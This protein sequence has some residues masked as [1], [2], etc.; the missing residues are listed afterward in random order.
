MAAKG[1]VAS[2][3]AKELARKNARLFITGNTANRGAGI[4]SNGSIVFGRMPQGEEYRKLLKVKKEWVGIPES[5]LPA[6]VLIKV[7]LDSGDGKHALDTL[8][9]T[10]EN[11]WSAELDNLPTQI[12]G[13]PIEQIL[14]LEE[15]VPAGM[16][17]KWVPIV[18]EISRSEADDPAP[19]VRYEEG[20]TP[21]KITVHKQAYLAV[22]DNLRS[23]EV[24][25]EKKWEAPAAGEVTVELLADGEVRESAV[26]KEESGWKHTFTG[27]PAVTKDNREIV[28]TVRESGSDQG[29]V[30]IGGTTY[31]SEITGDAEKGFT[32][33]NSEAVSVTASKSWLGTPLASVTIELLADGTKV[34]EAI[35]S[36]ENDWSHTFEGLQKLDPETKKEIVYTVR[37][38]GAASGILSV[39]GA[40]YRVEV[41]GTAAEGYTVKNVELTEIQVG[42]SWNGE[43]QSGAS[44]QLLADGQPFAKAELN[45]ENGWKHTFDSLDVYREDGSKIEYSVREIGGENGVI[46]YDKTRYRV[47]I[48]GDAASG[49][50]VKNSELIDI[51]VEKA[52]N[53][54]ERDAVAIEL[55]ANGEVAGSAELTAENGWKHVFEGL[56]KNDASGKAIDYA[57]REVGAENGSIAFDGVRYASEITGDANKGFK[58]KNTELTSLSVEKKWIGEQAKSVTVML[59]ANGQPLEE[60]VLDESNAWSHAFPD[61]PVNDGNQTPIEYSVR[62]KGEIAGRVVLD[63]RDYVV[64]LKGSAK[65]G[66][67]LINE[68]VKTPVVEKTKISVEKKWAGHEG[69]EA[70]IELLANG[71]E[72]GAVKLLK[73]NGWKYAFEDLPVLGADDMP[74]V[75]TVRERGAKDQKLVL[76]GVTYRVEISGD[77]KNGFTVTNTGKPEVPEKPKTP[78][79]PTTGDPTAVLFGALAGAGALMAVIERK[80]R[81]MR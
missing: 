10:K 76:D 75:Y 37:E 19:Y 45:A 50:A 42:K 71:E 12:D 3:E 52:W 44:I 53:G 59:L 73:A 28:Y 27:L 35:L 24:S 62:E 72:I 39:E 25:V 54:D 31:H 18:G 68:E 14:S 22:V 8:K 79:S 69:K 43:A 70:T 78:P 6:E 20:E 81:G 15:I 23:T 47:E 67:T 60:A 21:T 63:G 80:R 49:F 26:L 11:G 33:T 40:K 57:V 77:A 38:K 36:E 1:I 2:E 34:S 65:D 16:E 41:G 58:I 4:G 17:G 66:F 55:L 29:A 9:L 5:E 30:T 48:E 64:E 46:S 74:I 51:P 7:M 61:L 56:D 32:I 13:T